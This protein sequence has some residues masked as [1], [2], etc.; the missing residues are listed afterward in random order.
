[1]TQPVYGEIS[2][3]RM[4]RAVEK[5]RERL[6][7][8]TGALEAAGIPY[9]VV[10]GNAVAAWVSRIDEAAVRNTQDV[11]ILLRRSDLEAARKVMEAAGFVYRHVKSIDM[12][13]DGPNANAR[14]AVHVLMA[15]ERITSSDLIAAPDV[16]ES[17]AGPPFRVIELESLVRM[18]LTSFRRKDQLHLLDMIDIG[19]IDATWCE[20]VPAELRPR[21]EELLAN[22]DG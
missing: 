16:T 13:L 17:E 18:K 21:L 8:A 5:V 10:G 14:D 15:G 6:L 9:A 2:L 19:L 22:P 20:R 1:M 11:D 4:V 3:E 12:F 7:R